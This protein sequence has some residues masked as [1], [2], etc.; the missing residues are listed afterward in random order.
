[1]REPF[2]AEIRK[3]TEAI[4]NDPKSRAFVPLSDIYRKLGRYDEAIAV[5][6]DGLARHPNYLGA[7]VALARA[8]FENGDYDLA[9]GFFEE[10]LNFAPDNL[11]ANRLLA[12]IHIQEGSADRAAGLLKQL[13][14][15]APS[16]P[17]VAQQL[18]KLSA[19]QPKVAPVSKPT[20][21]APP[22]ETATL[23][24]LYRS[25]GHLEEALAIY[26]R[27]S[28]A[29]PRNEKLAQAARE[30]AAQLSPPRKAP[31]P[32]AGKRQVLESLLARISARRRKAA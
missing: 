20:E 12:Q 8:Y 4:A 2:E 30:I 5:A 14:A 6:R 7:K 9:R 22:A 32:P 17:W 25:Q 28:A 26:R 10:V 23:A 24:N 15:L 11:I 19:P 18:A 1:M 3:H 29:E 27:L 21:A 31:A 13:I 16:D